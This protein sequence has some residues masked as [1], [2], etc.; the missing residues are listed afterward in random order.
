MVRITLVNMIP[1]D[2]AERLSVVICSV[3]STLHI[4]T[5]AAQ[6]LV[7][8]SCPLLAGVGGEEPQPGHRTCGD[9]V[10]TPELQQT[11]VQ[12]RGEEVVFTPVQQLVAGV[13]GHHPV[14]HPRLHIRYRQDISTY[15]IDTDIT[16]TYDTDITECAGGDQGGYR[17]GAQ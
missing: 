2:L 8:S 14:G 10:S 12:W 13:G 7:T 6:L 16:N 1:N 5:L 4:S 9:Q 11:G 3:Q 17:R 15:D